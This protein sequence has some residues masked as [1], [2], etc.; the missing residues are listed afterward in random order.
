MFTFIK[1]GFR[2][3]FRFKRRTFITFSAISIGLALLIVNIC[4]LNGIDKQ[5]ISNIINCQTSHIKVF[6]EGYFE[7]RDDLPMNLTI[8]DPDS[9]HSVL[10]KIPGIVGTESRVLFGAGLIK[11]MDELPCLG[12][13]IEPQIDP[14]LFNIKESVIEGNWLDPDDNKMLVG[15]DLAEDIG[16]SVG[17]S[18]TVR[19]ITSSLDEEPSWN[20]IDMEIKGIFESGNPTVDGQRFI[21]PLKL[22]KESLSLDSEVTEIVVR[23]A[24]DDSG[25]ISRVQDK[26]KNTLNT[27][28]EKF[29]VVTWEDLAG[30]FLAISEMKTQR[31]AI[32]IIIMLVIASMGIINTMLMAVLE[33]TREIGMMAA[34]GMR[35]SEILR[36]FILEGMFIGAI[37]SLMGCILGGLLSWYLEVHGWS[38]TSLFGETLSKFSESVYPVKDVFYADL[39]FDVLMLTF[40][41]GTIISILAS[42]YPAR[43]AT[44]MNP[45]DALR[46][47]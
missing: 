11:G 21:L 19:M 37:G 1:L 30:T 3:I 44:K 12:V 14:G 41:F 29:D 46:H 5:S 20:A 9:I 4:L 8:K 24:S 36:L 7:K 18:V 40:V 26:I 6:T 28:T 42:V 35:K 33:R 45:I 43:K 27:E 13:A 16:L 32:I 25:L 31:S 34:M 23:L 2:N 15:K 17:D 22:A 39:T 47:I 38:I 10:K